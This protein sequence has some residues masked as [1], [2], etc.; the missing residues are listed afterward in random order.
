MYAESNFSGDK[1]NKTNI[2]IL[3]VI[4]VAFLLILWAADMVGAAFGKIGENIALVVIAAVLVIGL[5]KTKGDK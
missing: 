3:I 2:L 5:I 1:M 4:L